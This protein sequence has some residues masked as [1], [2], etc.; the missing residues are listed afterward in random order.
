MAFTSQTTGSPFTTPQSNIT[1]IAY[2][3]VSG[4]KRLYYA[5]ANDFTKIQCM[6]LT[7][8]ADTS[9][10]INV[11]NQGDARTST[12]RGL[13][14]DNTYL[15][16][17]TGDLG[18]QY[19]HVYRLSNRTF[20][21]SYAL[22]FQADHYA[23]GIETFV[24]PGTTERRINFLQDNIIRSYTI[25]VG[26]NTVSLSQQTDGSFTLPINEM[27]TSGNWQSLVW[28]STVNRLLVVAEQTEGQTLQDKVFGFQYNGTR[29]NREDFLPGVDIDA[30]TYNGDDADL[31]MVHESA[32]LLYAWGDFP[33]FIVPDTFDFN[34]TE[35]T[36]FTA[37]IAN[38]VDAGATLSLRTNTD[39]GFYDNLVFGG[40][41]VLNWSNPPAPRGGAAQQNVPL[42][43]RATIGGNSTDHTFPFV[44]HATARPIV[45][46]VWAHN[47]F[48]K[49]TVYEPYTPPS[50][51]PTPHL[52]HGFAIN[53]SD[54]IV[55]GTGPF[56][57]TA[58]A[59]GTAFPGTF[60]ITT[61]Y[62]NQQ[63]IRDHLVFNAS[64]VTASQLNRYIDI[65]VSNVDGDRGGTSTQRLFFDVVN[66][67]YPSYHGTD[68]FNV[69]D[70]AVHSYN[71]RDLTSGE[72]QTDIDFVG[73]PPANLNAT[74]NNGQLTIRAN[75][76]GT[77]APYSE[78]ITVK[79]TNILTDTDGVQ[80]TYTVNVAQQAIPQSAPIWR[81]EA[82]YLVTNAG[83]TN[84]VDLNQYIQSGNPAPYF[85][86]EG[87]HGALNIIRGEI[88]QQHFFQ[89]TIPNNLQRDTAYEVTFTAR[90]NVDAVVK[91][92]TVT[93]LVG[94]RLRVNA[95]P[96][97]SVRFGETW[98]LNLNDY[99]VGQ[100]T[101]SYAF[102]NEFTPPAGMTL[103][104]GTINYIPVSS[105]ENSTVSVKVVATD[106]NGNLD[107]TIPLFVIG[108]TAPAWVEDDIVIEVIEG[109]ST[110][111]DL[112]RDVSG[113]PRPNIEFQSSFRSQD[114][115]LT[116]NKGILQITDAPEVP[117]D[118]DFVVSLTA[119]NDAGEQDKDIII[120]VISRLLLEN[121]PKFTDNDYNEI[122]Y[123][124]GTSVTKT[125]LK[126]DVIA[127]SV[128]EES[129]KDWVSELLPY[130]P[131][132]PR[133][134]V[135]LHRKKRAALYRCAGILAG[136]IPS[137]LRESAGQSSKDFGEVDWIQRQRDLYK[138]AIEQVELV[139]RSE[140]VLV[141]YNLFKVVGG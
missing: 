47:A 82:I 109:G 39:D 121:L 118:R 22:G 8:T 88:V 6:S 26:T 91:D 87:T 79:Q 130:D 58:Q 78:S 64:S 111:Y 12:I 54:Y 115:V 35:G 126:D 86:V 105:V 30:M 96:R 116:L 114:L 106:E 129:A 72:P 75:A 34:I 45:N 89:Y 92:G 9:R 41:G 2:T 90:N 33:R 19:L 18:N 120:R 11:Q 80:K 81:E 10:E 32:T 16:A 117:S 43:I 67:E 17:I 7:G 5:S 3:N 110:T 50:G 104:D 101:I 24:K 141:T 95:I 98:T 113:H 140:K 124:L 14:S 76:L 102:D 28:D 63:P 103:T 55:T 27:V 62:V 123:L 99:V 70:T 51:A 69:S 38:L 119:D 25:T 108:D 37:N 31:Y 139:R 134:L 77:S 52:S 133:T 93:G 68:Q 44:L 1:A 135:N 65:T 56:T 23:R 4:T 29:D 20:V 74:L 60:Q 71:L 59:D 73:T 125:L 48:P 15:Y 131:D 40:N 132:K 85:E 100:G 138:K 94:E 127:S 46:P 13:C 42:T 66:L 53:L 107:I 136:H 49:Q 57:F 36:N 84:R 128:Y 83:Q 137:L 97:Q 21:A 61:R 112:N 122:R